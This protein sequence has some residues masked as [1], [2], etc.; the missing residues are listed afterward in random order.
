MR[1]LLKTVVQSLSEKENN[2]DKDSAKLQAVDYMDDGSKICLS[3]DMNGK[4]VRRLVILL[5]E[6]IC[7]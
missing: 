2:S 3:I 5:F 1:D 6:M 7:F 4:E